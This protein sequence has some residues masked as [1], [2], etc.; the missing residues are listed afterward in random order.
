MSKKARNRLI[1]AAVLLILIALTTWG[2][3]MKTVYYSVRS[4]KLGK[5]A[6]IV[7]ISDLHNCFFGGTDQS[8]IIKAVNEEAPDLVIFGGDVLDA[9][10]GTKYALKLMSELS[11][12]YPCCYTPGN[13][14]EMRDDKEEFYDK[15]GEIC[16]IVLGGYEQFT[17][18]DQDIRVYG[19]LDSIA[20]GKHDT[21]LNECF[22]TLDDDYYNILVAHQPEQI[23]SYLGKDIKAENSF[24][25]I[26]S[27]H[28]HGGQWR[29]PKLL[30]QGLYAPDQG[31]FP[32]YTTGMYEY[33]DT[34]HIISRGLAKPLRMIFI[35]RIFNR[36]EL[37]VIN[38]GK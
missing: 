17:V 28:A 25:L 14:E 30:D 2:F 31:I 20:W 29:I 36:P 32:K 15:V 1:A 12:T 22:K 13:H 38:I 6:K 37:S 11:L 27:G 24:D 9:W 7:F 33:D 23:D 4:D 18:K 26:L 21:Q 8:G 35:P 16:P 3:L 19:A 10:G 5:G 34:V